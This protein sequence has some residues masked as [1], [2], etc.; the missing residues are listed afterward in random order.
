[1]LLVAL[2]RLARA[3][4]IEIGPN[5]KVE[6]T[7][8]PARAVASIEEDR[9]E[10]VSRK[11]AEALGEPNDA[12]LSRPAVRSV[13]NDYKTQRKKKPSKRKKNA[14]DDLFSGLL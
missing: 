4:D 1:M 10:C 9:G 13:E 14:I 7:V 2:A 5:A 8:K 11:Q 6:S 3:T 12:P